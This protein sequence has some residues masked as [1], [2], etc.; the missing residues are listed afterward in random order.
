MTTCAVRGAALASVVA[1]ILT[2][3]VV[4]KTAQALPTK[5]LVHSQ[6]GAKVNTDESDFCIS[7]ECR[8][9]G[10]EESATSG[11]FAY[12]LS[13]ATAP[14]GDIYVSDT[15][16]NRVQELTP[17]GE[18]VLM[19]GA[20]V[21]ETKVNAVK[22]KGG[23]PSLMEVEEENVCTRAELEAGAKC[24]VG[25]SS[26]APGGL[27]SPRA[28]AV[29]PVH[30]NVYVA[31]AVNARI[32]EYT[33][34][35]RFVLMIGKEVNVNK[36]QSVK[37]KGGT[38]T[39]AEVEEENLCTEA[40]VEA[41]TKCKAG[42]R[43]TGGNAE[44][45]AIG[46]DGHGT[47]LA[48]GGPSDLLYAGDLRGVQEFNAEGK[49]VHEISLASV[50]APSESV[51][52]A[53]SVNQSG[54]VYV[55]YDVGGVEAENVI[56]KFD[57]TGSQ[58]CEIRLPARNRSEVV[59]IEG[60]A[61][62]PALPGTLAVTESEVSP[63]GKLA[64]TRY[65]GSLLNSCSARRV[66]EFR[67][68]SGG[69]DSSV[70]SL[71]FNTAGELYG[72][73]TFRQGVVGYEPK[74]V[75]EVITGAVVC[76]QEGELE[77]RVAYECELT[78]QIDPAGVGQTE[79]FFRWGENEGLSGLG[80]NE[81]PREKVSGSG[82][83]PVSPAL[84]RGLHPNERV[85]GQLAAYDEFDPEIEGALLGEEVSALVPAAPPQ[86]LGE[87]SIAF[88]KFASAVMFGELDPEN[89]QTRYAFQYAGALACEEAE[90]DLGHSVAL[91]ECPGMKETPAL[92]SSEYGRVATRL[93]ATGLQPLTTY[94]YGL[95]A[96]NVGGGARDEH[97]GSQLPQ[98]M[99]TTAALPRS[100]AITGGV[101]EVT[102][103][104]ALIS[105]AIEPE[106]RPTVYT[107]EVGL[108]EGAGTRYGVAFSG[109]AGSGTV[110]VEE[111]LELA[112]LQPG[113]TYAYRID[114]SGA[115]G[116]TEGAPVVFTTSELFTPIQAPVAPEQLPVPPIALPKNTVSP[117]E[118]ATKAR[119]LASALK[120]CVKKRK[121]K[122]RACERE[123]RKAYS[124]PATA[125]KGVRGS[126]GRGGAT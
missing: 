88:V 5:L 9:S 1:V 81:T 29:D 35:G 113:T 87:P 57:A 102:A 37:A 59:T 16:Q 85:Y 68:L 69:V 104:S 89:S 47:E 98:G 7:T 27:N 109:T 125:R 50:A 99:F 55:G 61:V 72:A 20:R 108:Y 91:N 73:S 117:P 65:Y 86:V 8:S 71:A 48:A 119:R 24:V 106:G 78:G 4:T 25:A 58:T 97:G 52:R 11:G 44:R 114:A 10:A 60:L 54:D 15:D 82:L 22:A 122:R 83:M 41:A 107:F 110:P 34:S 93:E 74:E 101:A 18:F 53:V 100:G 112:D 31:D 92:E 12:P 30:G 38:P 3:T 121:N 75:A 70:P 26:E 95:F 39:A 77:T 124:G 67:L 76:K 28:L 79:A 14:D 40:E 80:T 43:P 6:F 66:T 96:V 115:Y 103:T 33:A 62:D 49:W 45:G 94:R 17:A 2:L 105:G 46:E 23:T 64:E 42:I 84:V 120:A 51:V 123:A 63:N 32:E 21:N 19:Y 126:K 13:V 116:L 118:K 90:R 56:H 36:V 111:T